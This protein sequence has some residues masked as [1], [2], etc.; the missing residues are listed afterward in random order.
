MVELLH[1]SAIL[2]FVRKYLDRKDSAMYDDN[3]H[4]FDIET[5]WDDTEDEDGR[6]NSRLGLGFRAD[7]HKRYDKGNGIYR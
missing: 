2:M 4:Y 5:L 3:G 1:R 6:E 7:D